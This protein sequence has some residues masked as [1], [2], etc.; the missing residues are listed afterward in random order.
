MGQDHGISDAAGIPVA[1]APPEP[2]PP[3]SPASAAPSVQT[4]RRFNTRAWYAAGV[5]VAI[6]VGLLIAR[7]YLPIPCTV[8]ASGSALNVTVDGWAAGKACDAMMN[9]ASFNV[10]GFTP[11][12]TNPFGNVVCVVPLGTVTYTV[13]DVGVFDILGNAVCQYLQQQTPAAQAAASASA[14]ASDAAA[15]ASASAAAQQ[16]LADQQAAIDKDVSAV[17]SDMQSLTS[18]ESQV[19]AAINAVPNDLKAERKAL[20][21]THADEEA[22]VAIGQDP[23]ASPGSCGASAGRVG[24]DAGGVG[25]DQGAIGADGGGLN[26]AEAAV[27]QAVSA[28]QGDAKQ[29]ASDEAVLPSYNPGSAPSDADV[30]KAISDAQALEAQVNKTMKGYTDQAQ[31]MVDAADNYA[32]MAS[33]ACGT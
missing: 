31:S 32:S 26:A 25:A 14:E 16:Q 13:R 4:R 18:A 27:D 11:Y 20:D 23:N 5:I 9:T 19:S 3:G 17:N 28:L 21:Q 24:A 30:A 6:I 8:G 15:S 33:A 7:P 1:P 2:P 12:S 22:T 29:L 10:N